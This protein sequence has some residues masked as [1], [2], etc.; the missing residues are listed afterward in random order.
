MRMFPFQDLHGYKDYVGFVLMCSPDKF[1]VR[2]GKPTEYQW[3]L[4]LAFEGLRHGLELTV[5]EKGELPV[6]P[7]CRELVEKAYADYRA[8]RKR[9]GFF[10]LSEMEKLL[11]TIPS[12]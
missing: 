6:L 4:D 8:G 5:K 12:Q 10:T 2:D 11:K 3:T 7:R 9:E 1:T